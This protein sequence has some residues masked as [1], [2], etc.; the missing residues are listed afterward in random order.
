MSELIIS[1]LHVSIEDKE[2][3]KGVSLVI[4]SNEI[5]ALMGPNGNGKS[6]LL[7][8]IMGHPKY[9]VTSGSITL[10]GKDVLSMSVDER[11]RAGLFLAMQY[12]QEVPGV[13][14][15]DFLRAA[16]NARRETPIPLFSFIKEMEKTIKDLE[17]KPD[18]AHRFLNEGFS[19]G[20]KKRNEIV[21]MKLL[22]PSMAML[23]EIDSGL[24]VDALKIVAS[25]VVE[26]QKEIGC[27]VL[28]VSH[29][30]RFYQL[31]QPT[32]AHVLI[33]GKIVLEGNEELVTK[34]DTEGYE[35]LY[36]EFDIQPV[37]EEKKLAPL[38]LGSCAASSKGKQV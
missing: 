27:G 18:L 20:E 19:G 15:S 1:D 31:L 7:S 9:I 29:Y 36:K 32:H 26:L 16:I 33:D 28:A 25:S 22:K 30:E 4:K 13:T 37:L 21:Q 3:L 23:D 11:S 12:P 38:S 5:H 10:D 35:W 24:D 6:T 8:A 17:M 14:N 34:I 2:I